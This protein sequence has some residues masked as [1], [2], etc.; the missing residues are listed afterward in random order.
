MNL[1]EFEYA[2][3]SGSSDEEDTNI[4]APGGGDDDEKQMNNDSEFPDIP[5]IPNPQSSKGLP[6]VSPSVE[7][8]RPLYSQRR[9]DERHR[10]SMCMA[11][12]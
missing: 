12:G 9:A 11:C 4:N 3:Y 5:E 10:V 8:T 6:I 7:W 2:A 1:D